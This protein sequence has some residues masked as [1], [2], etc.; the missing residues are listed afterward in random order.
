MSAPAGF[1]INPCAWFVVL[2]DK[3][4]LFCG[5]AIKR[6]N[7]TW[8]KKSNILI[9]NKHSTTITIKKRK[10]VLQIVL[11]PLSSLGQVRCFLWMS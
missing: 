6:N 9:I 7:F 3:G 5:I 2:L 1:N 8:R 11:S 4:L 10:I